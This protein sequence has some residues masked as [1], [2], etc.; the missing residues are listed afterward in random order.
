[1]LFVC[2]KR[3]IKSDDFGYGVC[4]RRVKMNRNVAALRLQDNP[5]SGSTCNACGEPFENPLLAM[6]FNDSVVEEYYA[7]PNCLSKVASIR[8]KPEVEEVDEAEDVEDVAD[9]V[10][11]PV[12]DVAEVESGAEDFSGCLHDMGYLK[13]RPKNTPIPEE[14]L[15]CSKMIDCMY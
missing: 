2:T 12:A 13:R 1:V 4:L 14:C 9:E 15:T 5:V 11:E 3:F 8:Q 7:C 6:V 10:A